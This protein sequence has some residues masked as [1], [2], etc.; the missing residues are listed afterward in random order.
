MK[1]C[2]ITSAHSRYDARIFSRQCVTLA[3]NGYEVVLICCD[4]KAE[5][6]CNN[7]IIKSYSKVIMS[8]KDRFKLLIKNKSFILYLL[9][10]N[11][12][13]YQ[14]HDIEL[15][16]IGRILKKRK[17]CVVFDSHENWRGYLL[18]F[19]PD[20]RICRGLYNYFFTLYYK[21]VLPDFDAIFSVSPNMVDD[22]KPYNE[23]IFMVSNY[24]SISNN[25]IEGN[26]KKKTTY[27]VYAGTVYSI[28]N[29]PIIVKALSEISYPIRYKV[30]GRM[31]NKIKGEMLSIDGADKVDFVNWISKEELDDILVNSM[32]GI[33]LLDYDPICCY[34]EGQLGSNK[35]FEYMMAGIPVICTNFRLW[36]ELIIDKYHCGIA[37]NPKDVKALKE[38]IIF[39]YENRDE[40]VRM[41]ERGKEAIL[42][43]FNWEKYEKEYLSIYEKL[44]NKYN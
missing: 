18:R 12:D 38:A 41:G 31:S 39:I 8:K 6:V 17:K 3:R 1:I 13:V 23:N 2:H 5:E 11:A 22:L 44:Y 27:I 4:G 19:F 35:I 10:I 9:S 14:F 21:K 42:N 33:V 40:A 24:P 25:F 30:V 36:K 20:N 29:Q 28:S 7:V 16:E 34:E 15:L 32:A 26:L 37:I 43:E